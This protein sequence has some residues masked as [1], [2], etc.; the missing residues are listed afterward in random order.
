[1]SANESKSLDLARTIVAA[2]LANSGAVVGRWSRD[3]KEE[4]GSD[5][6]AEQSAKIRERIPK[7][8]GAETGDK[9]RGL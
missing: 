3:E 5:R 9:V 7:L 2:K 4:P 8:P 6:L 1:M